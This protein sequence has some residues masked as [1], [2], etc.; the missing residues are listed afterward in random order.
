MISVKNVKIHKELSEATLCF[1]AAVYLDGKRIG[2][3]FNRGSG[4]PNYYHWSNPEKGREAEAW[5]NDQDLE[6]EF[7]KLD[8]L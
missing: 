5:A 1:S 6:F 8:F 3:A 4:G 7:E 2:E